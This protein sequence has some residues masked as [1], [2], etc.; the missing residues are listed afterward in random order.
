MVE[1]HVGDPIETAGMELHDRGR[2]N[3]ELQRRVAELAG[4]GA[5]V[6]E[7]APNISRVVETPGKSAV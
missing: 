4:E 5:V 1:V 2:L 3:E 6:V 7:D